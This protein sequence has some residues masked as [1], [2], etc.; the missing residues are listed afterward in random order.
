[1]SKYFCLEGADG[2]GKSAQARRLKQWLQQEGKEVVHVREP[3]STPLA[4]ALRKTLLNPRTGALDPL[5]EALLFSAARSDTVR[6]EIRPALQRGAVVVA[7]RCYLSSYVYQAMAVDDGVDLDLLRRITTAVHGD[8]RPDLVL[9][10]DVDSAQAAERRSRRHEDR[11]EGRGQ[12][13]QERVRQA[14]LR[15]ARE[16]PDITVVDAGRP[17]DEVA[18]DVERAAGAVLRGWRV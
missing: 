6:R 14:F 10:L 7:E 13:F 16:E 18:A 15:L 17:I 5:T 9:L 8:A 11:F 12:E 2:C 1:M 3:G 4:E